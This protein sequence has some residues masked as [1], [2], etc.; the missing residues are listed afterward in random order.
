MAVLNENSF[1]QR[2]EFLKEAL[3]DESKQNDTISRLKEK[4]VECSILMPLFEIELGF[5]AVQD[6][7]Y[8]YTS[9]KKFDR[10]DF[11]LDGRFILEAKRLN[12]P[13]QQMYTQI[14]KYIVGDDDIKYGVLSNGS[15]YAFFVQKS[16]IKE[17]LGAEE[18]LKINLK[19]EVFHIMTLS[20][21]DS[22]FYDIIKLF[23]KDQYHQ[24]FS[25]IARFALTRINQTRSTKICDDKELNSW[26]QD[27]ITYTLGIKPGE[28]L[29]EIQN[30]T[31]SVGDQLIYED[32]NVKITVEVENDG[33]VR[34]KKGS[35]IVKNMTKVMDNE[36]SH[37]IDLVRNE[38]KTN[39]QIFISLLD[40]IK[41]ATNRDRLSKGKYKFK[42]L[43]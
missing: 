21:F 42:K 12:T 6:I 4:G 18:R 35:T 19:D 1:R 32:D 3:N 22:Q 2:I 7:H 9:K 26:I 36:F 25:N 33:Q 29:K 10:F 11:L 31:L 27:K 24:T 38:W 41:A 17:F 15:E 39:D 16:F 37:I 14:K 20:I 40:V 13:I 8:E 30:K 34:L 43:G 28:L 5:D 23:S